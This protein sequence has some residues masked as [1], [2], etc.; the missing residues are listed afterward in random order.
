M[1]DME[2]TRVALSLV[3]Q[4]RPFKS[5]LAS[6]LRYARNKNFRERQ[7]MH[8]EYVLNCSVFEVKSFIIRCQ[9]I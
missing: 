5:C 6:S 8:E 1:G 3:D 9:V 2:I 4:P 7:L